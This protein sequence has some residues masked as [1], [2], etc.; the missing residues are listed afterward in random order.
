[1][2]AGLKSRE[3]SGHFISICYT[4]R[5][6]IISFLYLT[7]LGKIGNEFIIVIKRKKA[8]CRVIL[9]TFQKKINIKSK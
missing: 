8:A 6:V 1:M 4:Y 3:V 9:R 7:A 2:Q 5:L